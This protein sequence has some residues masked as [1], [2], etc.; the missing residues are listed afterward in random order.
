[1]MSMEGWW[2]RKINNIGTL[3]EEETAMKQKD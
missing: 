3:R 2:R 1:M